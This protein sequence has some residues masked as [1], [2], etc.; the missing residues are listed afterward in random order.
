MMLRYSLGESE[1]ADAIEK[2][3]DIALTKVRTPDIVED[4]LETV[5]TAGMGDMVAS[6]V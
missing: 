4:G 1:A 5:N 2:A 6:L 3:V